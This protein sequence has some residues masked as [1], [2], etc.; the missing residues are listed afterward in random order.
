MILLKIL[1]WNINLGS[2]LGWNGK[3]EI[4]KDVVDTVFEKENNNKFDADIVY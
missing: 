3:K 4:S 2:S 1:T